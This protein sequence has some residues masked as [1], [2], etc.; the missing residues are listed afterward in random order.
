MAGSVAAYNILLNTSAVTTL[1]G[2]G[3][4]ARIYLGRRRQGTALPAIS[5][6]EDGVDPTDQ[7]PSGSDTG[8]SKLD[9]EDVL[10]FS[11]G[12][13]YSSAYSLAD[14]VRT[15]LDKKTAGTYNGVNV[16][17]VQFLG[18]DYFDEQTDPETF[19]FED[20]YRIRIIR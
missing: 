20:R 13:T 11:Y 16:Q 10:V 1:V 2:S 15:A 14:A 7:K 3:A 5:L 19:V 18:R 12:S 4:S 6:E 17:S 9:Q 8:V